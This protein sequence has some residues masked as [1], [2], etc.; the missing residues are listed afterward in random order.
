MPAEIRSVFVI[1]SGPESQRAELRAFAMAAACLG[2]HL[3]PTND[4]VEKRRLQNGKEV[5]SC[6]WYL[7]QADPAKIHRTNELRKWWDDP[8]WVAAHPEHPLAVLREYWNA[9]QD[10]AAHEQKTV[11]LAVVKKGNKYAFIPLDCEPDRKKKLLQML[12]E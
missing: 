9:L 6:E 1:V 11:P 2:V 7:E 10:A 12:N 4:F 8:A 3:R 5:R